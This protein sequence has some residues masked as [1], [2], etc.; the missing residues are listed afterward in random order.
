MSWYVF[1]FLDALRKILSNININNIIMIIRIL[2][3]ILILNWNQI[4][5]FVWLDE[6]SQH[7]KSHNEISTSYVL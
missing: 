7:K 4:L 2:N 1:L 5:N 3:H 6:I